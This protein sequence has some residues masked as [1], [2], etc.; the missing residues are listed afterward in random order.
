[1]NRHTKSR[2]VYT[3]PTE[4]EAICLGHAQISHVVQMTMST[5]DLRVDLNLNLTSRKPGG[6]NFV[7]AI[8]IKVTFGLTLLITLPFDFQSR[9]F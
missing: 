2:L 7:D 3:A 8:D 4:P 6:L 5:L 9:F 1:M